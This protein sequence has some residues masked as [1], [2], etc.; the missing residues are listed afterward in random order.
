[1]FGGWTVH[2]IFFA[3][4]VEMIK[5]EYSDMFSDISDDEFY[6]ATQLVE[7]SMNNDSLFRE[8]DLSTDEI[9]AL[10]PVLKNPYCEQHDEIGTFECNGAQ[11]RFRE[12]MS[13]EDVEKIRQSRFPK[14]TISNATW[15]VTL[16]GEW[17]ASR[18]VRC[19]SGDST[20]SVYLDKPFAQMN[21]S[22][23]QYVL[24]LFLCEV[25]KQ[26]GSEYPPETMRQLVASMQKFMEIEGRCEKFLSDS[27][28]KVF[29]IFFQI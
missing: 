27:K 14:K 16:F 5:N 4:P 15:A 17:R 29:R 28:Y 22:E 6:N 1:M 19:L 9:I 8:E 11:S 25:R 2:G 20:S 26:D 18:N 12:P 24:P 7:L 21:E 23:L 10:T 3:S 13:C